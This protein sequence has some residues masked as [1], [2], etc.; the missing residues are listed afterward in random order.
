MN[1][2]VRIWGQDV[3]YMTWNDN[4]QTAAFTYD[5]KFVE[6][7]PDISPLIMNKI[8]KKT[9]EYENNKKTNC[10][11]GL[12]SVFADSL[13]DNFGNEII[14][15]YWER[16]GRTETN[17]LD[18]LAYIGKRGMGALE[19]EP[20]IKLEDSNALIDLDELTRIVNTVLNDRKTFIDKLKEG[21]KT[22]LDILKIG[23]SAGGAKP[24]AVIAYN[25]ETK[26]VRSG[27]ITAPKGFG[28]YLLKFDS[29]L[30]DGEIVGNGLDTKN[31]IIHG[32]TN[33]EYAY[34]LAAKNCGINMTE[35]FLLKE[36]NNNH[37][38][39]KR[40][41]RKENGEKIHM[42][43]LSGIANLNRD[44]PHSYDDLFLICRKLNLDSNSTTEVF[45]R[46]VFNVIFRNHDDHAKNH[47]FL[48]DKDSKWKLAPAYD[49]SYSYN[50]TG[51]FTNKHQ[52]SI[53][54]KKDDIEYSDLIK[55]AERNDVKD[56]KEIIQKVI[57]C[58][59]KWKNYSEQAEVTNSISN[60]VEKNLVNIKIPIKTEQKPINNKPTIKTKKTKL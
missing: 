13:P 4:K 10:F 43:T 14:E 48:M 27:Q 59:K 28:Y 25:K 51:Q 38:V 46:M 24:K 42:L 5:K 41:D 9:Y 11:K 47:S 34:S 23:T 50:P 44:E 55:V 39:T 36:K 58:A 53:N 35:C 60:F 32:A 56:A 8:Y 17:P 52:M 22:F 15:K 20:S 49:L 1:I 37:F 18:Y 6:N 54:G 30:K 7:G 12:P 29:Y 31:K 16:I 19:Y 57:E 26:E 3:G 2:K 21:E 40:F 33:L 45:R